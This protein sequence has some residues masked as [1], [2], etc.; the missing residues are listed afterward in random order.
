MKQLIIILTILAS[1]QFCFS[2]SGIIKGH[3]QNNNENEG[4]AF[5]NVFLDNTNI[6]TNTDSNGDF[7]IDNIPAGIYDLKISF[8]GFQDTTLTSIKVSN[9]TIID[10]YIDYPPHCKY[11]QDDKTCPICKKKDKVIPI[12][13]GL[14]GK[15]LLKKAEKGKVK[16][17][18]C[19]I[20]GCDPKWYCKRDKK[21]F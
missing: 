2:Q 6:K 1:S 5:A 18:G 8:I 16:L 14:P 12:V 7:I 17:G 21:E 4:L 13:Y 9:D 3:V 19:I 11:K 20:T 10:L 15:R